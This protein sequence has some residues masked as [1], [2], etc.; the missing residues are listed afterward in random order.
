MVNKTEASGL[1]VP[2]G[3][4]CSQQAF[5]QLASAASVDKLY[6]AEAVKKPSGESDLQS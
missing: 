2:E 6:D 5:G 1:V 3:R 4:N